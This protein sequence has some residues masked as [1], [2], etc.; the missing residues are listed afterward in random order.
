MKLKL[1]SASIPGMG[2]FGQLYHEGQPL[3]KTVEREWLNNEPMVSCVPA[4]DYR[5]EWHESPKYG[6]KLHLVA[7]S[8]GVTVAGPSQRTHC[9]NH[10][11]N[12]PRQVKGCIGYGL[13][14]GVF[15]DKNGKYDF[16]VTDSRMALEVLEGLVPDDGCDLIIERYVI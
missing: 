11:A 15:A 10:K 1:K 8:L 16:G 6:Y 9:L 5:L 12:W 14:F 3:L 7:R 13:E 2:V 4:G